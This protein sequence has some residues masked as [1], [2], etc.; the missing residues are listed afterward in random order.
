MKPRLFIFGGLPASGK[1][2]LATHLAGLLG[3]AY[4][5]IDS[6]EEAILSLGELAGP[7]GYLAAYAIAA[8]NLRNGVSV[9]AD[10]VNPIES[11]RSAWIRVAKSCGVQYREIHIMCSDKSEHRRRLEKRNLETPSVRA[12]TWE[13][14]DGR[15]FETWSSAQAFDTAGETLE[16]SKSR[17]ERAMGL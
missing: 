16:E 5:R 7:E 13:D 15:E 1:S 14:V 17:F 2:A 4:I 12:L 10:S 11:T 6:I 3:A 8:D 9:I